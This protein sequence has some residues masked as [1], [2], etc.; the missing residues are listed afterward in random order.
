MKLEKIIIDEKGE[1]NIKSKGNISNWN[2]VPIGL[3]IT[4][5]LHNSENPDEVINKWSENKMAIIPKYANCYALS[6]FN[7]ST[8][9]LRKKEN[10]DNEQIY[11]VYAVQ[12]YYLKHF[13][14]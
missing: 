2:L 4:F 8:Q 3:P 13:V 14:D 9:H 6:E 12:F 7:G 1:F 10:E 11:S 5:L